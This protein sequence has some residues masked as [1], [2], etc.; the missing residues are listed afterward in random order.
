MCACAHREG[1]EQFPGPVLS[2]H[3]V[4]ARG[5]DGAVSPDGGAFAAESSPQP[6]L[7]SLR[8]L[9]LLILF[10]TLVNKEINTAT[11]LYIHTDSGSQALILPKGSAVHLSMVIFNLC[12]TPNEI[13]DNM[14]SL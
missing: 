11:E 14:F 3:H 6:F 1:R 5:G 2:F 7:N 9:S 13:Q 10:P 4:G 8:L 12:A